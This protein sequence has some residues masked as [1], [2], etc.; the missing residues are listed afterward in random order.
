VFS[1]AVFAVCSAVT[2]AFVICSDNKERVQIRV[3]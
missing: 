1:I 3:F 2:F